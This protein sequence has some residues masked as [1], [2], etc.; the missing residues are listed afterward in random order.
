[1]QSVR[2]QHRPWR[3][4]TVRSRMPTVHDS[5]DFERR[6]SYQSAAGC[7]IT[8]H[9]FTSASSTRSTYPPTTAPSSPGKILHRLI[10]T[11]L[12]VLHFFIL[13]NYYKKKLIKKLTESLRCEQVSVGARR[14][15]FKEDSPKGNRCSECGKTF[16]SNTKFQQ[17]LL[18]HTGERPFACDTCHKA[19]SSKFKLVR[20][21]LIHSDTRQFVCLICNR[22]FHRKDHLKNHAKVHNPV[23]R[24]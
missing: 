11:L 6:S 1:M 3:A 24:R 13:I 19:F 8:M 4:E 16:A 17:H 5:F 12:K 2:P 23:K 18:T 14:Q 22:T 20:H 9:H 7:Y 15:L 21:V 10:R